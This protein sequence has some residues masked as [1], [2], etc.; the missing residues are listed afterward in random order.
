MAKDI[1]LRIKALTA[2]R[3]AFKATTAAI[4]KLGGTVK[5]ATAS[6]LRL[7]KVLTAAVIGAG[8]LAIKTASDAAE[9]AQKFR[10]VF[11]GLE[12]ESQAAAKALADSFGLAR[13]EAKKLLGDVGD[14]LVGFGFTRKEALALSTQVNKLSVDLASFTNFEGGAAG[15]SKALTKAL[16]GEAESVKALGIVI[17][18]DTVEYKQLVSSIMETNKVGRIQAKALAALQIA[19]KQSQNAIGDF[20]RT[21]DEFANVV[22]KTKSSLIDMTVEIGKQL[23]EGL[24]LRDLFSSITDTFKR[25]TSQLENNK[26]VE[27]WASVAADALENVKTILEGIFAGGK[28][29]Q[30]AIAGLKDIGRNIGARFVSIALKAAPLI[31]DLIGRAMKRGFTGVSSGLGTRSAAISALK[32]EGA[33]TGAQAAGAQIGSTFQSSKTSQLISQKMDEFRQNNLRAQ[34]ISAAAA[35]FGE[36]KKIGEKLDIVAEEIRKLNTD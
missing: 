29:R 6:A 18:Q 28:K 27:K 32:A 34:G 15:A 30:I 16:L 3:K 2:I 12:K 9:A 26:S 11:K 31:G 13:T 21:Q 14:I 23:I 19:T 35:F 36:N 8:V 17:R 20:A 10:V 4:K 24:R 22:R 1:K 7:A 25:W 33:I 5:K